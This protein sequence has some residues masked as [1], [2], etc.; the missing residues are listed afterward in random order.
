M[1]DFIAGLIKT[2]IGYFIIWCVV[3]LIYFVITIMFSLQFDPQVVWVIVGS[4]F[5]LDLLITAGKKL[6]DM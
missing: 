3:A 6:D 4:I 1:G 5:F 2:V